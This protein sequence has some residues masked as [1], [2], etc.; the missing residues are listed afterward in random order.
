MTSTAPSASFIESH[1]SRLR[2]DRACAG[3]RLGTT[4]TTTGPPRA[5]T[6]CEGLRHVLCG[7]WSRAMDLTDVGAWSRERWRPDGS[8]RLVGMPRHDDVAHPRIRV[9]PSSPSPQGRRGRRQHRDDLRLGA[10]GEPDAADDVQLTQC[11]RDGAAVP[12]SDVEVTMGLLTT[13]KEFVAPFGPSSE[14]IVPSATLRS[15]PSSTTLSP[16]A[17]R[18]PLASIAGAFR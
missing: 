6:P 18:R 4:V 8:W 1:D 11:G 10:I 12:A 2:R 17:F 15:M 16:N 9:S 7:C 5:T 13:H 3:T 14:K